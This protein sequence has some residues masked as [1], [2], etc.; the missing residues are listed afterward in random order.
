MSRRG[1][2]F[3]M[4][5]FVLGSLGCHLAPRISDT[6]YTGTWAQGN[7][8]VVSIVA[9]ARAGDGYLFRWRKRSYDGVLEIRCGWDGRCEERLKGATMATYEFKTRVDSKTGHLVVACKEHRLAPEKVEIEYTDE[10]VVEPGGKV[11]T[12]YV[13]ERG[14]TKYTGGERP[15]RSFEKIADGVA[16]PGPGET[17]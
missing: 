8:R 17:R 7:D 11:L 12:S 10:L 9:I 3:A 2:A 16:G 14:G 13:I 1:L 15:M 6:G 5:A 4:V